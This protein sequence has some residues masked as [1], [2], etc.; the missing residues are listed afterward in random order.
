MSTDNTDDPD[1]PDSPQ[2][3]PDD[4]ELISFAIEET[5]EIIETLDEVYSESFIDAGDGEH[6]S[7]GA[8]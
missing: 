5:Q 7:D 8:H 3:L 1:I 2:P 6:T 4:G